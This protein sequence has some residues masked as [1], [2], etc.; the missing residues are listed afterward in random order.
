MEETQFA[1]WMGAERTQYISCGAIV[2]G[3][4]ERDGMYWLVWAVHIDRK[5]KVHVIMTN[6]SGSRMR[7]ENSGAS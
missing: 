3:E 1:M 7:G 4:R 5:F 6:H 2:C